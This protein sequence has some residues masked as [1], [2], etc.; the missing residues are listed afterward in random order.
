MRINCS[1]GLQGFRANDSRFWKATVFHTLHGKSAARAWNFWALTPGNCR[2]IKDI[3]SFRIR[4]RS[5]SR[6]SQELVDYFAP[7]NQHLYTLSGRDFNW[8]DLCY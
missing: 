5:R 8:D 4:I 3:S 7:H 1:G 6:E 2:N